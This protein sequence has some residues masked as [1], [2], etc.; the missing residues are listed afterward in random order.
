M[1]NLS[2]AILALFTEIHGDDVLRKVEQ[3]DSP[4]GNVSESR[5]MDEYIHR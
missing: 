4:D 2:K 3:L 5:H 1:E